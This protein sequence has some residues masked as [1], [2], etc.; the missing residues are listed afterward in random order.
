VN[1]AAE[2]DVLG[3]RCP[4]FLHSEHPTPADANLYCLPLEGSSGPATA[5]AAL[6]MVRAPV[7]DV[8]DLPLVETVTTAMMWLCFLWVTSIALRPGRRPPSSLQK[9]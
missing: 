8:A 4:P 1:K 9:H 7:G 3:A 2:A 6:M 5:T